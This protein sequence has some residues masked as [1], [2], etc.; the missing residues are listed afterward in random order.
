MSTLQRDSIRTALGLVKRALAL[1]FALI[2]LS[3]THS[4]IASAQV[5]KRGIQGGVVG[6]VVG[7]I[8][9]GGRGAGK[10]AA[11]GAGVGVV[12]G[13][14]EAE[15]KARRRAASYGEP[16]SYRAYRQDTPRSGFGLRY[17]GCAGVPWLQSWPTRWRIWT[18]HS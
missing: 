15:N 7:G 16:R 14:I 17:P 11:I 2:V 9:D 4:G 10:G 13:A 5:L 6:A 12:A 3:A 18:G 8:V 1:L